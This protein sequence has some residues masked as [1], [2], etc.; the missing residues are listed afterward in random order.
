MSKI[1]ISRYGGPRPSEGHHFGRWLGAGLLVLLLAFGAL[2]ASVALYP[3]EGMLILE[4]HK[5]NNWSEDSYTV[6]PAD[7]AAQLDELQAQGYTTISVLDFLRAKKGKQELPEKPLVISFDDGYKDNYTDM[8]PLLEERGMKATVFMVTNDIGLPGYLSWENLKDME[9][10]GIEL[11]SHTANHLPLTEMAPAEADDEL[12]KSKLIMEWK[13]LK[14]IFVL[15]Y[16]NGQYAD[17]L[18]GLLKKNDYLAAVTGDPGLNTFETN[19]Y[20]LQRINI[21]RPLFGL[22]EFRLRLWKAKAFARLGVLQHHSA[23]AVKTGLSGLLS[24]FVPE[25]GPIRS[26]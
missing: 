11:G 5:I 26:K 1:Y 6:K 21:P 4:Y 24:S 7:F 14:T 22:W 18:P 23:D 12:S 15:S 10:R 19:P 17:H 9:T 8:L 25:T 20:L 13:G 2:A 3:P 16:P